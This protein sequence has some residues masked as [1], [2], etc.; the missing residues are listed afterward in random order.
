MENKIIVVDQTIRE[1]MQHKGIVF[2]YLQRQKILEFQEKL[3]IDVCQA[4]YAPAHETEAQCIEKLHNFCK[5]SEFNIAIA[6]MGRA[7]LKDTQLLVKTGINHFHLHFQIKENSPKN[8]VFSTLSESVKYIRDNS[9]NSIISIAMLDIGKTSDLLIKEVIEY[10]GLD[11]CI[12]I[13]SLPDTSGILPPNL[14]FDKIKAACEIITK[15]NTKASAHCHNDMG[16]ANANAVMGVCAGANV[17]EVS[18]LGIGERNGI[19]DLFVTALA[20]QNQGFNLNV[21][22]NDIETF[23]EYYNYVNSIY[24]TQTGQSLLNY[25]TPVFGDAVKS[26]V[27][28]THILPSE[29]SPFGLYSEEEYYINLLCGNHLVEKYLKKENIP[30]SKNRLKKITGKIKSQ[31][32]ELERRLYKK[33]IIEIVNQINS[34]S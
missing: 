13:I 20:L 12:D 34:K 11:L 28:G 16:M 30:F 2:S 31:S 29:A 26:H 15:S 18:A 21:R 9:E 14:I 10:L 23:K 5:A 17:L 32:A 27:A 3:N 7:L 6:G 1:G 33:E 25:N 4:G 19:S 8:S 22:T 24:E